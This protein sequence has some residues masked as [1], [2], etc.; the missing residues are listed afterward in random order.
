[1]S[2]LRQFSV[3]LKAEMS[4]SLDGLLRVLMAHYSP[5]AAGYQ[6]PEGTHASESLPEGEHDPAYIVYYCVL[7]DVVKPVSLACAILAG[8]GEHAALSSKERVDAA[9]DCLA[10]AVADD[11]GQPQLIAHEETK[12]RLGEAKADI[13]K[14]K[15][16]LLARAESDA[17]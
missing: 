17:A 6:A 11:A 15:K 8:V 12:M 4:A 9:V 5:E 2:D 16:R 3:E 14:A 13:R 7:H 1:M 10:R